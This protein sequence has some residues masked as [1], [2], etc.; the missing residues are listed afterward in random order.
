MI[1]SENGTA[2][3][4]DSLYEK[5]LL[6]HLASIAR[7]YQEGIDVQGYFWWAL[8]DNF[9]WE[10]GFDY[11]FGLI[12]VDYASQVRTIRPFAHRYAAI[13]KENKIDT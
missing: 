13:C 9:E 3:T 10:R 5:Y 6:E 1:I 7:A 12:E 4:Q 11:R 2:E 8:L